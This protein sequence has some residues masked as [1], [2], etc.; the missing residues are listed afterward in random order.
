[1]LAGAL[2]SSHYCCR[3]SIGVL[4][5]AESL[6]VPGLTALVTR[7]GVFQITC[8]G[9]Q[10]DSFGLKLCVGCDRGYLWTSLRTRWCVRVPY[11]SVKYTLAAWACCVLSVW[12]CAVA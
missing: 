8:E 12:C 1:M 3:I 5:G 6:D 9:D 2:L 7:G 10:L 4:V 11:V